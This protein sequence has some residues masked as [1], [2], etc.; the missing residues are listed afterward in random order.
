MK[1]RLQSNSIRLRLKRGEV[2]QI[3]KLGRVEESIILGDGEEDVFTY[4]LESSPK[5]FAPQASIRKNHILVEVPRETAVRWATGNE[6]GIEAKLSVGGGRE[7]HVIIE[8]DFA[9][10]NGTEEQNRD[11]FPNPQAG[12]PC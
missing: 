12:T 11:T 8:K 5:V 10:L 7:L 6:V 4:T 9:C 1:L 2:D 3:V